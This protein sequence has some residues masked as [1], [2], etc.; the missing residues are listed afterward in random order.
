MIIFHHTCTA[1]R[2]LAFPLFYLREMIGGALRISFDVFHPRPKLRP[3]LVRVPLRL[4]SHNQRLMLANLITMTP[5]TL[6]VD[7]E[8]E[9]NTLLVHGLYAGDNPAELVSS[10]E[11]RYLA[12]I[13]RLPI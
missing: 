7:L 12:V 13:A 9:G 6:S 5:G 10:I 1:F 4:R 11:R 8:D 2:L 3:V